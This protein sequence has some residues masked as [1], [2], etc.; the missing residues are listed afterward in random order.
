MTIVAS[1]RTSLRVWLLAGLAAVLIAASLG[2]FNAAPA[3]AAAKDTR[4]CSRG[5]YAP[6]PN[7]TYPLKNSLS[8]NMPDADTAKVRATVRSVQSALWIGYY[9]DLQG[10]DTVIDG[11]YGPQT[12]HAVTT[13]QRTHHLTRTGK[14]NPATW[15]AL[16]RATCE[17][18]KPSWSKVQG[19]SSGGSTVI[20]RRHAH[21]V[22]LF[23]WELGGYGIRKPG[24]TTKFRANFEGEG[25]GGLASVR[26]TK[27]STGFTIKV[28]P[29]PGGGMFGFTEA[30]R[31]VPYT[32]NLEPQ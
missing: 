9:P 29:K 16:A 20:I 32:G 27:T 28:T 10:R 15:R 6:G 31:K 21:R 24:S 25:S 18:S 19:L 26:I 7:L 23:W 22:S 12:A 11:Y 14:V 3:M 4:L 8:R 2:G 13:F 5:D 1:S 30:Y 17:V